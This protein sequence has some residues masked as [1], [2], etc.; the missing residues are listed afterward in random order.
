[1]TLSRDLLAYDA[2]EGGVTHSYW[3]ITTS[4]LSPRDSDYGTGLPTAQLQQRS[5]FTNWDFVDVW[6]IDEGQGYPFLRSLGRPVF[7]NVNQSAP[8]EA[9][10]PAPSQPRAAG[11]LGTSSV[12]LRGRTL[13]VVS[14]AVNSNLQIRVVD[15]RGRTVAR[16]NTV[17]TSTNN[18]FPLNNLSAG[19]YLVE[20][21][22]INR[23]RVNVS[24]IMVR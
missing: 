10:S 22:D 17:T 16:F 2:F 5:T 3:D 12:V 9:N 19:R 6:A 20:V 1:M 14:P 15:L 11:P 24:P 21:R 4:G 7:H 23:N 13:S 8:P 18:R